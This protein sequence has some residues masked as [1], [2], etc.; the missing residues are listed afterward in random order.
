MQCR[1]WLAKWNLFTSSLAGLLAH[2]FV[3]YFNT[4]V[5]DLRVIGAMVGKKSVNRADY[6]WMSMYRDDGA[7]TNTV[8]GENHDVEP[9]S[10]DLSGDVRVAQSSTLGEHKL[11]VTAG[12]TEGHNRA[13][14]GHLYQIQS[15]QG[16]FTLDH[17]RKVVEPG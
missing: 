12:W 15:V 7:S 13:A 8:T 3:G 11:R 2:C 9:Y 16:R 17:A 14:G 4:M 6:L 10:V 1:N 5:A